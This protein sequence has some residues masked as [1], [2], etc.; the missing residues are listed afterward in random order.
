LIDFLRKAASDDERWQ[1]GM[2]VSALVR[3]SSLTADQVA[4]FR[5]VLRSLRP[6]Y[7]PPI[8]GARRAGVALMSRRWGRLEGEAWQRV[9]RSRQARRGPPRACF[10]RR[11][12]R[13]RHRFRERGGGR[14]AGC[15]TVPM[16]LVGSGGW[17]GGEN[18]G[19]GWVGRVIAI[20]RAAHSRALEASVEADPGRDPSGVAGAPPGPALR[21][22]G[23]PSP[24]G[25]VRDSPS[26][27]PP[28]VEVDARTPFS[29]LSL[30]H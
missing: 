5:R 14:L 21:E 29:C 1:R 15:G 25:S 20:A 4:F 18:G 26:D 9:S 2:P 17:A 3:R 8:E 19:V 24:A 10:R 13:R 30:L 11:T 27:L 28:G 23:V 12:V 22:G 7:R 6:A 16:R